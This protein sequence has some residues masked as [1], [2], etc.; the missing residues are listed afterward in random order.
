MHVFVT[1]N[2]VL[3]RINKSEREEGNDTGANGR[4]IIIVVI[5]TPVTM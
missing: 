4:P 3:S 5:I 2:S 1:E